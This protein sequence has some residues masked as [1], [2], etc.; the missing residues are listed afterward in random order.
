MPHRTESM[1]RIEHKIYYYL[2]RV[3][4]ED[5]FEVMPDRKFRVRRGS[6]V[7]E[8]AVVP[9][10]DNEALVRFSACVVKGA[11]VTEEL[12]RKL[13]ELNYQ[14]LMFGAFGLDEEGDIVLS[15]AAIGTTLDKD[16]LQYAIQSLAVL[17]DGYDDLIVEK[18]G[19]R[20]MAEFLDGVEY[21]TDGWDLLFDYNFEI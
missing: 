5:G 19:G 9:W 17:A 2:L 8:V 3:F 13:M 6:C 11:E 15:H 20:T 12:I 16:E 4:G 10:Q 18:H 1:R 14:K 21:T 7:V